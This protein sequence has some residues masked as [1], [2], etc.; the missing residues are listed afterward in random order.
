MARPRRADARG[1]KQVTGKTGADAPRRVARRLAVEV[2]AVPHCQAQ[3]QDVRPPEAGTEKTDG[4]ADL[5]QVHRGALPGVVTPEQI[6]E[7]VTARVGREAGV[8][9]EPAD[10]LAHERVTAALAVEAI[11]GPWRNRALAFVARQ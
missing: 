6:G 11:R 3:D 2:D 1:G 7:G 9:A 8:L 5:E 10:T 4:V